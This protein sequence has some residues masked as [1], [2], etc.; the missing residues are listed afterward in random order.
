[1]VGHEEKDFRAFSLL[2]EHTS[3]IYRIQEENIETEGGGA[4]YNNQ[5][6][7]NQGNRWKFGRGQRRG[8]FGR[9]EH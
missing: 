3:N 7:F 8:N 2:R 9:G 1:L 4:Q 6:G 5:R